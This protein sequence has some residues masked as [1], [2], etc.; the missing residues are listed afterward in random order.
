MMARSIGWGDAE[1]DQMLR[2]WGLNFGEA[3]SPEEVVRATASSL[4]W[5]ADHTTR[6]AREYRAEAARE[7]THAEAGAN[8]EYGIPQVVLA[9]PERDRPE[10]VPDLASAA[11]GW[12]GQAMLADDPVSYRQEHLLGARDAGS[13][14][15]TPIGDDDPGV[16]RA[17][18]EGRQ[19]RNGI[20]R[21]QS[22]L[23][24]AH[25]PQPTVRWCKCPRPAPDDDGI[26]ARCTYIVH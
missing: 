21:T 7:Q 13:P 15:N 23:P 6:M 24:A 9:Y 16:L 2:E 17:A 10:D 18:I 20:G 4:G 3:A 5:G 22:A 19:A 1:I 12:F 8:D 25:A 11:P 26:C 14:A